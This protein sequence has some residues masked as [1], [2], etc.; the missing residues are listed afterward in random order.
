MIVRPIGNRVVIR[1]IKEK[2]E[3]RSPSGI[4]LNVVKEFEKPNLGEIIALGKGE[5]L[6]EVSVGDKIIYAKFSG[7]ELRDGDMV[8]KIV[9]IEDILGV[10][11][12]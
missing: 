10:V 5:K 12:E 8:L 9:D 2:R 6:G 1:E 3:E 4:I 7:T 11:E